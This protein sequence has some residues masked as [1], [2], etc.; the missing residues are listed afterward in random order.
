[1]AKSIIGQVSSI[2]G[3]KTIV[4]I[5]HWRKTHPIYKK[6]YK[7]SAKYMAH[8]EK[9]ETRVGDKVVIEESRPLSARKRYTLKE[10][11]QRAELTRED[12]AIFENETKAE[13]VLPEAKI[14]VKKTEAKP[15]KPAT[16]VKDAS[17]TAKKP[18]DKDAEK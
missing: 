7:V 17:K 9:N 15:K 5:T 12:K 18:A 14:E 8:D 13:E 16:K 10:I 2:A 1:M 11:L 4:I 6:Q 3:N